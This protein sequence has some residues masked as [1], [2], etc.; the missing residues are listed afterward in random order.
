[1]QRRP[2]TVGPACRG[3]RFASSGILS[4]A[5]DRRCSRRA[6]R[7]IGLF[8][9]FVTPPTSLDSCSGIQSSKIAITRAIILFGTFS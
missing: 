2:I 6:T 1:M 9:G 8:I 4:K 7:F 3:D 5:V